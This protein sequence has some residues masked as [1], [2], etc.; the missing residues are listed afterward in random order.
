M[1]VCVGA[2]ATD[3]NYAG[4]FGI[5]TIFTTVFAVLARWTVTRSVSAFVLVV[6][7]KKLTFHCGTARTTIVRRLSARVKTI[8]LP[9]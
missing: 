2:A 4:V 8:G 5:F 3:L 1:T 6:C 9:N 7:H